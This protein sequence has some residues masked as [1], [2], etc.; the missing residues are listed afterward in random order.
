MRMID[1]ARRDVD[2]H[3]Q[4]GA[5]AV[6]VALLS[7]VLMSLVAFAIDLG[8]AWQT[9][10]S[11]VKATDAAA[12]AAARTARE[13]ALANGGG[14]SSGVCPTAVASTANQYLDANRSGASMTPDGFCILAGTPDSAGVRQPITGSRGLVTVRGTTTANFSFARIFGL[15]SARV[16]SS[17]TVQWGT[18]PLLPFIACDVRGNNGVAGWIDSPTSPTQFSQL[19]SGSESS[20]LCSAD[21]AGNSGSGEYGM[22]DFNS[23]PRDEKDF[24]TCKASQTNADIDYQTTTLPGDLVGWIN[25]G[26]T[27]AVA[28]GQYFCGRVGQTYGASVDQALCSARGKQV[29]VLVVDGVNFDRKEYNNGNGTEAAA[30]QWVMRVKGVALVTVD[31]YTDLLRTDRCGEL[32]YA[33]GPHGPRPVR[34]LRS[35][36]VVARKRADA[37]GNVSIAQGDPAWPQTATQGQVVTLTVTVTNETDSNLRDLNVRFKVTET[38]TVPTGCTAA[39]DLT[40]PVGSVFDCPLK[41]TPR[42]RT[43]TQSFTLPTSTLGPVTVSATVSSASTNDSDPT[44][45]TTSRTITIVAPTTTT[46][47]TT[48]STTT[49][50]LPP[51]T[52]STSTSNQF[53]RLTMTFYDALIGTGTVYN[54]TSAFPT[55]RICDV[56][57]NTTSLAAAP[58]R[59]R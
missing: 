36:P 28:N 45:N 4:R 8:Y 49:T 27:G 46:T 31:D 20:T 13:A 2:G 12:L 34:A 29:A 30:K 35:V 3:R 37:V 56:N 52:T 48:S 21:G 47:T 43:E 17:S 18:A 50:T 14:L 1:R 11:M 57:L 25:D 53:R 24:N 44:D 15:D 10:R 40:F 54:S 6:L 38:T 5:V 19:W 42:N 39:V 26:Y 22:V 16:H 9:Q 23:Q 59:C 33:A 41:P 7:V 58:P 55:Y 51:T 32:G